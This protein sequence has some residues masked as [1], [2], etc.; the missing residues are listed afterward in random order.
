M[1]VPL[2]VLSAGALF[3][4]YINAEPFH[5]TWLGTFLEHVRHLPPVP[6]ELVPATF[7]DTV[8]LLIVPLVVSLGGI[9]LAWFM[10]VRRPALPS[11]VA[12]HVR[13]LYALSWNKFHFDEIY[14]ALLVAPLWLFAQFCRLF[15]LLVVDNIVDLLG[16][17][18]R[19]IGW[20]FRPIQN[21]LVQFYALAMVCGLAVFLIAPVNALAK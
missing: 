13:G 12:A 15:D 3:A 8:W 11:D 10:Y 5:L 17:V 18:P 9:A 7:W 20:L 16:N 6:A 1:V 14:N 4:G 19:L 2:L 21:G